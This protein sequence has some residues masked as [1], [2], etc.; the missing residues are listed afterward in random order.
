MNCHKQVSLR[1]GLNCPCQCTRKRLES[2]HFKGLL[3][4]L[5]YIHFQLWADVILLQAFADFKYFV[6]D[7]LWSRSWGQRKGKEDG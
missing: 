5:G 6:C 4:N 7:A 2:F 1:E 3:A